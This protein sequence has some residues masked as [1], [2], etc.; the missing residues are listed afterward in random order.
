M[1]NEFHLRAMNQYYFIGTIYP[2]S[3]SILTLF[4]PLFKNNN[5]YFCK[6][7]FLI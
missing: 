5:I 3:L 4:P 7:I 6:T 2:L 1:I